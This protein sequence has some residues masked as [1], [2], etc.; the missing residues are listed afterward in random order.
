MDN[1]GDIIARE[2]DR[3]DS[4]DSV[5]SDGE[6]A[7]APG[8]QVLVR[9]ARPRRLAAPLGVREATRAEALNSKELHHEESE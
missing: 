4:G 8:D 7:D 2:V 5:D 6:P 9:P 1:D 3:S